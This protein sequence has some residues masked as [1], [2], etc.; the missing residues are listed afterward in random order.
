MRVLHL[1]SGREMRGGQWQA[2]YLMVGQKTM[3]LE[4]M[5]LAPRSSPLMKEAR[6]RGVPCGPL[7]LGNVW[8]HSAAF[9]IVHA[10]DAHSHTLGA[11]AARRPLVVSRRVAFPVKTGALSRWKYGRAARFLAISQCVADCLSKAGVHEERIAIVYDGVPVYPDVPLGD[12]LIA[13]LWNDPRKAGDLARRAATTAGVEIHFS[14]DLGKDLASARALLYLTE[15]EG[16]GSGALLAMGSGVPVI[17]SRVGG[18]PEIV[19][20][21]I[22][23]LLVENEEGSVAAAIGKLMGNRPLAESLGRQASQMVKGHFTLADM[24]LRTMHEYK[25]VVNRC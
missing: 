19:R 3:G 18:L 20:D 21:G 5:L 8:R 22:T 9:D 10:H 7:W 23:G 15:M 2:L 14:S 13:P 4:P 11:I 25:K 1:D 24:A 12:R 17:A 16:L 6:Q